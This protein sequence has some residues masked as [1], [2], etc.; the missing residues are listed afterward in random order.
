MDYIPKNGKKY[1]T[2]FLE[3]RRFIYYF[4]CVTHI[5]LVYG[6]VQNFYCGG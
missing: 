5:F 3:I 1:M 2:K 6:A 4:A